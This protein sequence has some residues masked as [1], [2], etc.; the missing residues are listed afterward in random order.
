MNFLFSGKASPLLA[1]K[2]CDAPL[3]ALLKKNGGV[4]VDPIAVDEILCHLASGLCCQFAHPFLSDFSYHMQMG[5]G[6]PG[7]VEAAIHAVHH[8]LSQFDE[9]LALLK[10][11]MKN[12]FNE[13]NRLAFLD[14]VCNKF[15]EIPPG[16]IGAT[17][18][19]LSCSLAMG[20]FLLRP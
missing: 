3:T 20:V 2:L 4:P 6:I 15:P 13:R 17:I 1:P 12:A 14:G 9:S 10:I 18:I 7:G 19:L 8:S 5:V 11:D 16:C